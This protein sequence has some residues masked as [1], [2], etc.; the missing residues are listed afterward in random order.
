LAG[1]IIVNPYFHSEKANNK[2]DQVARNTWPTKNLSFLQAQLVF[3]PFQVISD[4]LS[5]LGAGDSSVAVVLINIS[6]NIC[7]SIADLMRVA[8]SE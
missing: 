3:L 4:N 5:R 1:T 8:P 6:E 7:H 2:V